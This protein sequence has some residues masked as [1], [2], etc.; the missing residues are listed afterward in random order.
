MTRARTGRCLCGAVEF[1][2]RDVRDTI[3]V[4]HCKMCQRWTGLAMMAVTVPEADLAIT[5]SDSVMTYRSSDWATR[6]WCGKCGSNLWYRITAEGPHKG[7]YEIPIGLF[8]DASDFVLQRELFADLRPDAYAIAGDHKR[9]S[10][11]EVVAMFGGG[12]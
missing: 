8:N 12:S 2:A 7:N 4:C 1:V 11:A 10:E 6:S 5:G 3:G 9:L